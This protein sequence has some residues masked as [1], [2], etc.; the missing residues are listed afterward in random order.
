M[1]YLSFYLKCEGTF[2]TFV[3]V[4]EKYDTKC[5]SRVLT[6]DKRMGHYPIVCM[7]KAEVNTFSMGRD[8]TTII[9]TWLAF[10][11]IDKRE[12][13]LFSN[14]HKKWERLIKN[15]LWGIVAYVNQYKRLSM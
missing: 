2:S 10:S 11:M 8:K 4:L 6:I 14:V 9:K 3:Y 15:I 7:T 13:Y 1:A 5:P 12:H